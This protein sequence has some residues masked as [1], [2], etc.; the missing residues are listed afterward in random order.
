M[1]LKPIT[2]IVLGFLCA[3]SVF[4]VSLWCVFA[5]NSSTTGT[6]RTQRLHREEKLVKQINQ[7][8]ERFYKTFIRENPGAD[9]QDSELNGHFEDQYRI[10][11]P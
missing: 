1:N 11:L 9:L 10:Y 5:R 8:A 6:Q 3:T 4:S 2:A 7:R